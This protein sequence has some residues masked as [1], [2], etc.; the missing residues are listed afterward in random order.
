MIERPRL[1]DDLLAERGDDGTVDV[2]APD[3][4]S[5]VRLY[6]VEL[7]VACAMDGTRDSAAIVVWAKRELGLDTTM[8]EIEAVI[9]ALADFRC[10][11]DGMEAVDFEPHDTPVQLSAEIPLETLMLPHPDSLPEVEDDDGAADDDNNDDDDDGADDFLREDATIAT[12]PDLLAMSANALPPQRDTPRGYAAAAIPSDPVTKPRAPMPELLEE[13]RKP[14]PEPAPE[15]RTIRVANTTPSTPAPVVRADFAPAP[16]SKPAPKP[17]TGTSMMPAVTRLPALSTTLRPE[18][19]DMPTLRPDI[20]LDDVPTFPP[21]N[22]A[23]DD[24]DAGE[25]ELEIDVPTNVAPQQLY[26]GTSLGMP[27]VHQPPAA[28]AEPVAL[29]PSSTLGGMV[30]PKRCATCGADLL[31]GFRFC[32]TC[33][34]PIGATDDV[35]TEPIDVQPPASQPPARVQPPA[36]Q[37]P[38]ASEPRLPQ[39]PQQPRPRQAPIPVGPPL[40]PNMPIPLPMTSTPMIIPPSTLPPNTLPPTTLPPSFT[41]LRAAVMAA[42]Q[43]RADSEPA[44]LSPPPPRPTPQPAEAPA[45]RNAVAVATPPRAQSQPGSIPPRD[46]RP[47]TPMPVETR[48][49]DPVEMSEFA[50][51]PASIP[52]QPYAMQPAPARPPSTR[53]AAPARSL[54][55]P[56]LIA[57]G[58]LAMLAAAAILYLRLG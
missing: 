5:A 21:E 49:F 42:Q 19:I 37:P 40:V 28:R 11:V 41:P 36:I 50:P 13:S 32:T 43:A 15:P 52:P 51:R 34:T 9:D 8:S 58:V 2:M 12:P 44:A 26:K 57:V 48:P 3:G 6:D 22:A 33:G 29:S 31:A 10:V 1:R 4:A 45:M 54:L 35:S 18:P 55:V 17:T 7:A 46:P 25:R 56:V 24:D 14:A 23:G 16:A 53:P 27:I 38:A 47:A 20:D 39:Q 30:A